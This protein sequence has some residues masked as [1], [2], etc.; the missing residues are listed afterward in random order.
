MKTHNQ[1]VLAA[2]LETLQAMAVTAH[3][4]QEHLKQCLELRDQ[5]QK[6][7]NSL[8]ANYSGYVIAA[9]KHCEIQNQEI[10]NLKAE[11][12]ELCHE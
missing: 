1:Q 11:I 8:A 7:G 4:Y 12:M 10:A 5:C 2:N 3:L 9:R 6:E